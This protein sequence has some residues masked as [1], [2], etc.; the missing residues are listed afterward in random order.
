MYN[1]KY[2][3]IEKDHEVMNSCRLSAI[4][5][6]Y[7]AHAFN[8]YG[9]DLSQQCL[10]KWNKDNKPDVVQ[11]DTLDGLCF[12]VIDA[13]Q[14][15]NPTANYFIFATD[16]DQKIRAEAVRRGITF[17]SK[18]NYKEYLDHLKGLLKPSQ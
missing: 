6:G 16:I 13:M 2:V 11:L 10:F 15:D 1:M 17:I 12:E 5:V 7:E 9:F 18:M 8:W 4:C 3:V 14:K